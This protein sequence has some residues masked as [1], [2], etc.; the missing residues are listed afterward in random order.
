MADRVATQ[1]QGQVA[2]KYGAGERIRND[3]LLIA[4]HS[5]DIRAVKYQHV[6]PSDPTQT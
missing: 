3:D 5:I 2:E 6:T 4:N 1:K